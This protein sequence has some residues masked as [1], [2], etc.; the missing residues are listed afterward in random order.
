[1]RLANHESTHEKN[2]SV[3]KAFSLGWETLKANYGFLLG[4]TALYF[5][6]ALALSV[7]CLVLSFFATLTF[8]YLLASNDIVLNNVLYAIIKG[9]PFT[10]LITLLFFPISVGIQWVYIQCARG[11]KST[12]PDL[13][14]GFSRYK[15]IVG[16]GIIIQ[17]VYS[18]V[19]WGTAYFI[20]SSGWFI[21]IFTLTTTTLEEPMTAQVDGSTG[22]AML[23][24]WVA[25]IV[26]GIWWMFPGAICIDPKM[27]GKDS[28]A[29]LGESYRGTSPVFWRLIG[30]EIVLGFILFFCTILLVLPL[31]FLGIPLV[32][33]MH[34]A[35][36]TL[37]FDN[38]DASH[39]EETLEF[40]PE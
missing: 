27:G 24:M 5:G 26:F 2:F 1:M 22:I 10:I 4:M 35:A 19:M 36:Y 8:N 34:G 9:I 32:M 39:A 40:Q 21:E 17:I 6:I 20:D 30:M 38:N 12:I 3:D 15:W 33:A 28:T 37:I 14:V 23:V 11:E 31:F 16:I 29:C 7:V 18:L 13:F 25:M